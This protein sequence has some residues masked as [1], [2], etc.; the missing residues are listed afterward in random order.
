[1]SVSAF[2]SSEQLDHDQL[3]AALV[4]Y[5]R[6]SRL[7]TALA[8]S[9][10]KASRAAAALGLQTI[11]DLLEHLP[12]DRRE[13][14]TVAQLVPGESATIVVEVKRISSRSVRRRGMRPLV[15]ATVADE[16]GALRATFFNQPWLVE[17]YP[18]GTR[19]VLHGSL[20]ARRR[21]NVQD[22]ARTGGSAAGN[23]SVAHYST[24]EGLTSSELLA[25]VRRHAGGLANVL[26]PLPAA[27]RA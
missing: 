3:G 13:A 17:R 22:H 24:T 8:L 19:L 1:M 9:G 7:A 11:G 21:F 15:Q 4:R 5:P 25:L 20:S 14:R 23:G 18:A 12:R 27:V 6:P 2:A 26:E 10:P 16:T